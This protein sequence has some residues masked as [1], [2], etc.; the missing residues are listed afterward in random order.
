KAPAVNAED[1]DHALMFD[2]RGLPEVGIAFPDGVT[3][4]RPRASAVVG[5]GPTG[6]VQR[7]AS[8]RPP[9]P[10]GH[11]VQVKT[12]ADGYAIGRDHGYVVAHAMEHGA[13]STVRLGDHAVDGDA[14]FGIA[15]A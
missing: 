5:V 12:L 6:A 3:R 4:L 11:L 13:G 8:R 14:V 15:V 7:P 1:I 9:L 10:D 2:Q